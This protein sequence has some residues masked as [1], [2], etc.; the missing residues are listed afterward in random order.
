MQDMAVYAGRVPNPHIQYGQD[1]LTNAPTTFARFRTRWGGIQLSNGVMRTNFGRRFTFQRTGYLNN[2]V[3]TVPGQ[4]RLSGTTPS[5]FPMR[6]PAPSQWQFHVDNGPGSQPST[7]GGP[8][9][10]MGR[11]THSGSYGC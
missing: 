5:N 4:S 8:G 11:I 7:P 9:Q 3:Q 1:D 6:G 10:I 2:V